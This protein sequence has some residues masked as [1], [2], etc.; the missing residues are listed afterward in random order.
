MENNKKSQYGLDKNGLMG[1]L[2]RTVLSPDF[3][4]VIALFFAIMFILTLSAVLVS[5]PFDTISQ[6]S[7]LDVVKE[8]L[9]P[10]LAA[11]GFSVGFCLTIRGTTSIGNQTKA[12]M[13][14]TDSNLTIQRRNQRRENLRALNQGGIMAI[15][16]IVSFLDEAKSIDSS[17]LNEDYMKKLKQYASTLCDSLRYTSIKDASSIIDLNERWS[18]DNR[19]TPE[20]VTQRI[21]EL[22]FPPKKSDDENQCDTDIDDNPFHRYVGEFDIDLSNCNLQ[23]IDFS[24]R[25]IKKVNFGGAALHGAKMHNAE[26]YDCRFWGTYLQSSNLS[27]SKFVA[28]R[29]GGA[30]MIWTNLCEATFINCGF[31][32]ADMSCVLLSQARFEGEP[33]FNQTILDGADIYIGK[34]EEEQKEPKIFENPA[35]LNLGSACFTFIHPLQGETVVETMLIDTSENTY[36]KPCSRLERYIRYLNILRLGTCEGMERWTTC[37]V[38]DVR[39]KQK[40][41]LEL[42]HKAL[43]YAIVEDSTRLYPE[44]YEK[45]TQKIKKLI[46]EVESDRKDYEREES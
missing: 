2:R 42:C 36:D 24:S 34:K 30:K 31:D 22:L 32:G 41:L 15:D 25:I 11:V 14:E 3:W 40:K 27:K 23:G 33:H 18:G 28:C 5:I 44:N 38:E 20:C 4:L 29:F 8:I 37:S 1:K 19:N 26:F 35:L 46:S 9:V 12:L 10:M 6:I 43:K 7:L 21:V 39:G 17:G 16:V 45:W 13:A